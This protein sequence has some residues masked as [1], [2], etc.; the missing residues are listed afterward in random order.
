[1]SIVAGTKVFYIMTRESLCFL[2]LTE[3]S[4]PKRMAFLYLDEIGDLILGELV[5]EFGNN[6]RDIRRRRRRRMTP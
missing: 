4:Y 2:T 1:M 3:S 5:R 6:V